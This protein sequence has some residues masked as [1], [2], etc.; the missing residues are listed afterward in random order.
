[1]G[2]YRKVLLEHSIMIAPQP[3]WEGI[4]FHNNVGDDECTWFLAERGITL[5]KADDCHH[6][7]YTWIQE[8]HTPEEKDTQ[9]WILFSQTVAM[10]DACP[11]VE[12]WREPVLHRFN[13]TY[14]RWVPIIP[15]SLQEASDE[16]VIAT[17]TVR[18]I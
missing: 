13:E 11:T 17:A 8:N 12:P 6:F 9:L 3:S 2:W 16:N 10:A 7:T 1:M 14:T 5:D 4:T 18:G 15:P